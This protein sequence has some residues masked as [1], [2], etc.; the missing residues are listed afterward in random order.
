MIFCGFNIYIFPENSW[1]GRVPE[2][3]DCCMSVLI[4]NPGMGGPD[5][6]TGELV[7][8]AP[9]Q[10]HGGMMIESTP[11]SMEQMYPTGHGPPQY[12]GSYMF[13]HPGQGKSLVN[14]TNYRLTSP[15]M[16]GWNQCLHG[17]VLLLKG[18]YTAEFGIK[19]RTSRSHHHPK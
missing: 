14:L 4:M 8:K 6:L 12:P 15:D 11:Y 1:I 18:Y 17:S 10:H 3:T 5:P 16:L 13:H 9:G 7:H 19:P 2:D